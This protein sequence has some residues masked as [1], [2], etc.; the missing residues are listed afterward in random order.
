MFYVPQQCKPVMK[1]ALVTLFQ[2]Q[3]IAGSSE[4]RVTNLPSFWDQKPSSLSFK[5]SQW[6]GYRYGFAWEQ[7]VPLQILPRLHTFVGKK[8]N[9]TTTVGT[10]NIRKI[11]LYILMNFQ[12]CS[13]SY[14]LLLEAFSRRAFILPSLHHY[15]GCC[16]G[17]II[18]NWC[19]PTTNHLQKTGFFS[20][21]RK[22]QLCLNKQKP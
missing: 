10:I 5:S 7:C 20:L 19:M 9:K 15:N 22:P 8:K 11:K 18:K 1:E 2:M 3:S 12:E 6:N 21:P 17:N 16:T 14:W 13:V 4:H